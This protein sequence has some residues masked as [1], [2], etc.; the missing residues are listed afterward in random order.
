MKKFFYGFVCLVVVA[1]GILHSE[2]S[3]NRAKIVYVKI[4]D[5][6]NG[7]NK[8]SFNKPV[9]IGQTIPVTYSLLLFSNAR[10]SGTEFVG[11]I[12][13]NQL[14]LRNPNTKWRL[15]SDGTYQAVYRYKIKALNASIPALKVIAVSSDGDYTD[16]SI[17]PAI[18][19]NVIDLYQ[20]QNYVGVVADEFRITGYRA[21]T[22][23]ASHNILVF[24]V[25]AKNANLEDMKLPNIDKQGFES[26]HFGWDN[27]DGIYYCIVPKSVQEISFEYFSLKDNHFQ[28]VSL[29]VLPVD[30]VVSTQ[31]DIKPKNN[32]LLFSNLVLIGLMVVFLVVYFFFGRKKIFLVI[33]GV[34]LAYWLWN[35]FSRHQGVMLANKQIRILPT[36]NSTVLETTKTNI[37]VEIIGKH[38]K[39]YKVVTTDD[40]I[41][42]VKK[43][44]IQ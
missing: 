37:Q 34:L 40:K 12:N 10:F 29:P 41:G 17:A 27:S 15:S 18:H 9:Y 36:H 22:Y 25:E 35:V 3:D 14:I 13:T 32:L 33:I 44:D 38:G 11:G 42:W 5:S 4:S 26:T 8:D 21:K 28:D 39:Y 7:S 6:Q 31:D 16:F 19:L 2:E 30:D 24:E 23:D 1:L 43:N 20:N